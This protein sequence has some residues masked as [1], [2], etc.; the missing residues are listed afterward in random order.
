[1]D[2][3]EEEHS[4]RGETAWLEGA[5]CLM[6]HDMEVE[7]EAKEVGLAMQASMHEKEELEKSRPSLADEDMQTILKLHSESSKI[8][9]TLLGL[10]QTQM[11]N[12]AIDTQL[13]LDWLGFEKRCY[14]WY[15]LPSRGYFTEFS[16]QMNATESPNELEHLL[17]RT[18]VDLQD[19][20]FSFPDQAGGGLPSS[21]APYQSEEVICL[22]TE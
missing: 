19:E 5:L 15:P 1:M 12:L 7:A 22:D 14:R 6:V 13:L 11:P 20:I 16:S 3:T 9:S 2:S 10:S 4:G 17:R 21:F 18:L 8:A